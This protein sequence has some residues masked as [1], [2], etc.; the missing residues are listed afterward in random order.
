LIAKFA[1]EGAAKIANFAIGTLGNRNVD[2]RAQ[3][4]PEQRS[5]Q[6][7]EVGFR[8]IRALEQA[9]SSLP[10]KTLSARAGMRP[11]KAH[12]YLVSF[13]RIGLVVQDPATMQYGLGP[14]AVQLG[15]AALHQI[16]LP[17][18]AR[19][20]LQQLNEQHELP[21]YL[22]LWGRMGPFIAVKFD[23]D[24]PTPFTIKVGFVFPLLSTATGNIFLAHMAKRDTDALVAREGQLVPDLLARRE[25]IA[26]KV[27][28]DG[29]AISEG[30][31]FRGFS[32]VAAPIFDHTA[33]LAGSITLLGIGGQIDRSP[34]GPVVSQVRRVARELSEQ[35][36]SPSS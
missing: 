17:N 36:G 8:L 15:M 23:A 10:L 22:S 31:L 13:M 12:L 2:A 28:K 34:K 14:Y 9:G 21:A 5:I 16:S 1:S 32:A 18:L 33:A 26:T 7:V 24:L 30:R 3:D 35:L 20:P 25:K 6:S 11:G 4:R 29:F 19:A 27:R